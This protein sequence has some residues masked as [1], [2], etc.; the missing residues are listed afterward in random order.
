MHTVSIA[1]TVRPPQ[2]FISVTN[3]PYKNWYIKQIHSA[4]Y[5]S[6]IKSNHNNEKKKQFF[7]YI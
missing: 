3:P 6:S 2:T 4:G 1:G 7:Y 5:I